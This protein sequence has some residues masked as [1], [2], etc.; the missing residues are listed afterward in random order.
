MTPRNQAVKALA[1][2]PALRAGL[3]IPPAHDL[4]N[5]LEQ[6][7]KAAPTFLVDVSLFVD[8]L[9]L[10]KTVGMIRLPTTPIFVENA[11]GLALLAGAAS[12]FPVLA[13]SEDSIII[14][15]VIDGA[16]CPVGLAIKESDLS[17]AAETGKVP[18]TPIHLTPGAAAHQE[19]LPMPEF[20]GAHIT[21]LAELCCL[22]ACRN[23]TTERGEPPP[24]LNK[25]RAERGHPPLREFNV[26]VVKMD[27]IRRIGA[28]EAQGEHASPRGHVRRGHIRRLEKGLTWV[29]ACVVNPGFGFVDKRY[30]IRP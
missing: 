16:I 26:V 7:L 15:P 24:K 5:A 3:D 22:L 23:L 6:A 1:A 28:G 25:R 4:A 29:S 21:C 13:L 10:A 14:W 27:E 12:Y 17:L 18:T 19:R 8:K 2:L 20:C 9:D 30:E 11:G